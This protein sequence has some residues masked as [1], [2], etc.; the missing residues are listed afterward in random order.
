MKKK[1]TTVSRRSFL[2]NATLIGASG[3]FAATTLLTSSTSDNNDKI[4]KTLIGHMEGL[5]LIDA[6]EHL[7][8]EEDSLANGGIDIMGALLTQYIPTAFNSAGVD[9]KREW[10]CDKNIPLAERWESY[11]QYLPF[12]AHTGYYRTANMAVQALFGLKRLDASNFFEV[13][14]RIKNEV[15]PGFYDKLLKGH[16]KIERVL[17]QRSWGKNEGYNDFVT[18]INRD[19]MQL[20]YGMNARYDNLK[21]LWEKYGDTGMNVDEFAE[22]CV[23]SMAGKHHGIKLQSDVP[24]PKPSFEEAQAQF[25]NYLNFR[26][27]STDMVCLNLYLLHKVIELCGKY[28]LVVAVHCGIIWE[29]WN[30]FYQLSVQNIV[31]AVRRYRDTTFDLYHASIPWVRE[32][33]VVGNQY[34]NVNLNLTWTHEISPAMTISFLDEWIDL[35]PVNKIIGFGADG[36]S[37]FL[38]A[39]L[40]KRTFDNIAEVLSRRVKGDEMT[41]EEAKEI[42]R[43]WLYDN[44]KRI[45]SL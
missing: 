34:P 13:N 9:K 30:D 5:T 8:S 18:D 33:G 43:M 7:M 4:K 26:I 20:Q 3:T 2:S 17:N 31:Q 22:K 24:F 38:T 19:F 39:G 29:C 16:C 14:E 40:R 10:L 11:K 44:P 6:H 27:G 1:E 28:N 35:V 25:K 23:S 21:D 12:V 41:L 15:K 32:A 45:Y 36:R 37:P 42:C